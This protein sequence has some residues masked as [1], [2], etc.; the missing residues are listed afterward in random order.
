MKV[1]QRR[2]GNVEEGEAEEEAEE[3][4]QKKGSARVGWRREREGACAH[5]QVP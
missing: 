1:R 4:A 3:E 2:W 5:G